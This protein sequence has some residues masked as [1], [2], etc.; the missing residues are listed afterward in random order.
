MSD[1]RI[2][3]SPA[4]GKENKELAEQVVLRSRGQGVAETSA[5]VFSFF[6]GAEEE[7]EQS[8][9]QI[10]EDPKVLSKETHAIRESTVVPTASLVNCDPPQDFLDSIT[11][12]V[13]QKSHQTK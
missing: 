4:P 1:L 13:I 2:E 7:E 6:G 9:I 12:E 11:E 8:E 10:I 5:P 3:A